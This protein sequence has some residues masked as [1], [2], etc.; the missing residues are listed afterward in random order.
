MDKR[1]LHH[2]WRYLRHVHPWYFLTIAILFGALSVFSLRHNNEQMIVLRDKVYAADKDGGDVEGALRDLRE[3]IY[4][5]MNTSLASGANAVYPPI[6]LKYTYERLQ[7]FQQ[8]GLNQNNGALYGEAEKTC[9]EQGQTATAQETINCIENYAAA[10]GVQLADIP[11][12]LYKFDFISAKWSPDVA[13]WSLVVTFL[14]FTAFVL[15]AI[16]H[17]FMKRY[18]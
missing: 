10:H 5:H 11:D 15:S 17:W 4:G 3:Y 18:L 6:Q 12:A 1:K 13:G 7:A 9:N 16:Y 2:V 14:S 8:Q